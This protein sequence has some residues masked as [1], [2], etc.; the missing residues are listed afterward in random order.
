MDKRKSDSNCFSFAHIQPCKLFN[1]SSIN[2]NNNYLKFCEELSNNFN[3]NKD[4]HHKEKKDNDGNKIHSHHHHKRSKSNV[5]ESNNNIKSNIINNLN[6]NEHFFHFNSPSMYSSYKEFSICLEQNA[7]Y[8]MIMED[9]FCIEKFFEDDVNKSLFCLFDG[10]GGNQVANFLSKHFIDYFNKYLEKYPKEEMEILF[11]K[12][13]KNL[14]LDIKKYIPKSNEMG[15]TATVIFITRECDPKIGMKKIIYCANIGD[16]RSVLFTPN[17]CKRM[18]YEHK[19]SDK[20]EEER[21][22]KSKGT[23]I[24][25]RLNGVLSISR[26]F[27]DF[28]LKGKGL[29]C[30]PSIHKMEINSNIT[31]YIVLCTDGV[32]DFV[33]E[34]DIFYLTLNNHQTET[35]CKEIIK[36]GIKRGSKDNMSCIVIK[37]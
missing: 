27:G 35:I 5:I 24:N 17:D 2:T 10:H 11:K 12:I 21:I 22:K 19:S 32:W 26:A 14:D 36:M 6:N 4:N 18:T 23:I 3:E 16:T 30:E 15:S 8:L 29:T 33:N 28:F 31:N 34:E 25:N 7:K 9:C 1:M 20:F 37:V 13:F